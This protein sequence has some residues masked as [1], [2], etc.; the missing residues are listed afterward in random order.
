MLPIAFASPLML[1]GLAALP[2]LWVLLRL[3]P[4]RPTRIDFPPLKLI[5]DLIPAE[6]TPA[7]TPWWLTLLRM[8]IAALAILMLAGP[9]FNPDP[10]RSG[11][12]GPLLLLL[13]NGWAAAHDWDARV[14]T[15]SSQIR[16]AESAGR[17][18]ALVA[19]ADKP[20]DLSL[21][22]ASAAAERLRALEPR[23]WTPDRAQ[24]LDGVRA[25]LAATADAS[26]VWYSDGLSLSETDPFLEGLRGALGGR[27]VTVVEDQARGA[28][29]LADARNDPAALSVRVLRSIGTGP[30]TG[31]IRALDEKGLPLGDAA[32]ALDAGVREVTARFDL[33]ID[34]RNEVTRLEI[35]SEPSAGAVQ[36]LDDRW[37]RRTVGIASGQTA[38]RAQPLLSATYFLSQA[39]QPFADVRAA[40]GA[41]PAEAIGRFIEQK[42]PLIVLA[43][44]GTLGDAQEPLTRWVEGGGVLIRFAGPRLAASTDPLVPVVLRRGDRTLGGALSW[45]TPQ[46]LGGFSP[47]SPFAGLPVPTDVSVTRQ[48]LAEPDADLP[49]RVWATLADGTPLVTAEKRGDGLVVLFHVTADA[50]W[51]NLPLTGIF[52][53]MLRRV[54]A[55]A[56]KAVVAGAG[57]GQQEV[58]LLSP[59]RTLDGF[60]AFQSPPAA[61]EPLPTTATGP[62][63]ERHPPGFY[64][65][66]DGRV[67]VN[68]L[69]EKVVF[70]PLAY[71]AMAASISPFV[72]T[73]ALDLRPWLLLAGLLL[74]FIDA[75]V[76]FAFG[77]G[78]RKMRRLAM[79]SAVVLAT[80]AVIAAPSDGRAQAA[81]DTRAFASALKTHLAYV[82]TGDAEVDETS[83]AGLFGLTEFITARTALEPGPPVGLNLATDELAFHAIIYWPIVAGAAP[84]PPAVMAKVD[85][86]MKSGGT[87]VF[88]TRDALDQGTD[89]GSSPAGETLRQLLSSLDI[90]ALEVVPSN[91]VLTKTFFLME[92]FPGRY[93]SG[94]TWVEATVTDSAEDVDRPALAGDGVTPIVI[95]SNDLAAAW[96]VGPDLEP[97]YPLTPGGPRQREMA[98]RAG[99]NI[100]MYALTGNYKSDQ[101]HVP[102]LL[103]RLGQ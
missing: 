63:T 97:L 80:L 33:P 35:L 9:V 91:H 18:V 87:I 15:I 31:T 7:R 96:A 41:S 83:R 34:L 81:D 84:P 27:T 101:V 39:F 57:A 47:L 21:R 64:G 71:G 3:V 40:E 11:G 58:V 23:P 49:D 38:D 89:F 65:P 20:G 76:V 22:S 54:T 48:V 32:F 24:H 45:E 88:D 42:L 93:E 4:P 10:A 75:L 8:M 28:L 77:G 79:A 16:E 36:L 62:A 74:L 52:V 66:A 59:T 53:D 19:L 60:G 61:A 67:A 95:T 56:G 68:T 2:I 102:A 55:M 17:P 12:Q 51:S 70:H 100:V 43:D 6:E 25:F 98:Y 94:A 26:V 50:T 72:V 5:L 30:M 69:P 13:D 14:A 73:E 29:A 85:A 103:E 90:P 86:F 46:A 1:I 37:T 99:V 92:T 78:F 82:I 44:V